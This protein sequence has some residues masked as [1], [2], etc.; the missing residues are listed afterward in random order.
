MS[1]IRRWI[2]L[3]EAA[4]RET[5]NDGRLVPIEG[6]EVYQT[7]RGAFGTPAA[8]HGTVIRT[9]AGLRVKITGSSSLFGG[10]T[11]VGKTYPADANWTVKND[12][13]I[14]RREKERERRE[15]EQKAA[16]EAEQQA[17]ETRRQQLGAE[18][19]TLDPESVKL[20]D[21]LEDPDGEIYVVGEIGTFSGKKS[22]FGIAASEPTE[23]PRGI[24]SDLRGWR[25]LPSSAM[26]DAP[27]VIRD[28][29]GQR[30]QWLRRKWVPVD[31]DDDAE[32]YVPIA[33]KR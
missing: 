19:G 8:I 16:R 31:W 23:A 29:D 4:K 2:D 18:R 24:G 15:A 1:D 32:R 27:F 10:S 26:P 30:Y 12:P 21:A 9:R 3:C 13:E 17:E 22:L 11:R 5:R 14:T 33:K 20:G 7:V 28:D 25:K 6:D